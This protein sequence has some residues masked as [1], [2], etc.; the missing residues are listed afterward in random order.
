MFGE[1]GV[2]DYPEVNAQL[3]CRYKQS[4]KIYWHRM[5]DT[6]S[7]YDTS[8]LE[9]LRWRPSDTGKSESEIHDGTGKHLAIFQ[10]CSL[11]GECAFYD[12]A[13]AMRDRSDHRLMD[14]WNRYSSGRR[15][16]SSSLRS[17]LEQV[18]GN[19]M[20]ICGRLQRGGFSWIWLDC[21]LTRGGWL[22]LWGV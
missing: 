4:H 19:C 15:G 6:D 11:H 12:S 7:G 5:H 20:L 2:K 9:P 3:H 22:E 18:R 17:R 13:A 8:A 14:R 16:Q 10:K 21:G 1:R